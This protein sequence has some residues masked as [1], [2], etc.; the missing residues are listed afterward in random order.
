[1]ISIEALEY[2]TDVVIRRGLREVMRNANPRDIDVTLRQAG[3]RL[4]G[5]LYE[6]LYEQILKTYRMGYIAGG[7]LIRR[8]AP[9]GTLLTAAAPIAKEDPR[10]VKATQN[11]IFGLKGSINGHNNA[12]Q[13]AIRTQ[14]E[15]GATMPQITDRLMYYF[16]DDRV[17]TERFART[18]TTDIYNRAKLDRYEESG[19]V[20]GVQYS[21]H[22]DS[23]TSEICQMLNMTIW[24][25]GDRNI[26][27]P[28]AHF[29]CRSDLLPYFGEIPGKRDFT[30]DFSPE[31]IRR[32]E[33][34]T[35]VFRKKYWSPMPHTRASA[36]YQRS[37]FAK[38]DIKTISKGLN[39][40]IKEE[41]KT[42]TVPDVI[43]LERLKTMLR[44][45]KI[46]PDK[47]VIV[48]RLGKSL[49]LDK[50]E[51][52]DI[53][54]SVKAL[55][56][57]TETRIARE[58]AKRKRMIADLEK[59]IRKS[60][61]SIAWLEKDAISHRK[62][63]I[64]ARAMETRLTKEREALMNAEPS[65]TMTMLEAEKERYQALLDSFR[66]QER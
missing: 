40:A 38:G 2:S 59:S 61:K 57:Q 58:V 35:K 56:T 49:L 9:R 62:E 6:H 27:V 46:D 64:K 60:Q 45:R 36:P 32:A 13:A 51:E 34:T 1:M 24:G 14:I 18:I 5:A 28:P 63:L 22:I 19:V 23:R 55:I 4:T 43:P 33:N 37:Y 52:R 20:D 39:L 29:S 21:A 41:R 25:L 16:D 42:S 15:K 30:I 48:D 50:F 12:I 10:I 11:V 17:A 65:P 54:R 8:Y 53:I 31:F 26:V 44:Y 3:D 66:F 47:S 7:E